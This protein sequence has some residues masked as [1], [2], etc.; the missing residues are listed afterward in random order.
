MEVTTNVTPALHPQNLL[1]IEGV[2]DDTRPYIAPAVEA[3]D[4]AYQAIAKIHEGRTLA[5]KNQAWTPENRHLIVAE[6]AEKHQTA[7]TKKFDATHAILTKTINAMDEM[8]TAPV[9]ADAER[10]S[11]SGEVRAHVKNLSV[12]ERHD[13]LNAAHDAGDHQTLRAILGAP[14]YLSGIT[15]QERTLR[16]R[17]YHEKCN[18]EVANRLQ[19]LRKARAMIEERGGLVFPAVEKAIGTR[20]D[21]VQQLRGANGRATAALKFDG[22]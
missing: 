8:L 2:N 10:V 7:I 15:D 9:K 4:F 11:I 14:S 22:L 16:T 20:W 19:V 13:F 21:V 17:L 1:A 18:P 5:E 12:K 6:F 3:F